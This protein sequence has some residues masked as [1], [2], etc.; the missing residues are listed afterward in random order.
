MAT[1][2]FLA[3]EAH[4]VDHIAPVWAALNNDIRGTFITTTSEAH[5]RAQSYGI[6]SIKGVAGASLTLVA[7]YGDYRKTTG[8]VVLMEHGVGHTYSNDH[9][10]YAG[11]PGKDRVVLFL[12]PNQPTAAKNRETYPDKPVEVIGV[13]KLDNT[14]V[15]PPRGRTAAISF[16]WDARIAPESRTA[17]PHY[18]RILPKLAQDKRFNLIGHA[19][20]RKNWPARLEAAYKA[21]K[22]PYVADF[23]EVL[24][25][26]D[27][28][29][30]DVSSTA[31]EFAAAGRPV[32]HLNAPWYRRRVNHGIRYWNYL[33]GPMVD[34][35]EDLADTIANVLDNPAQYEHLRQSAA[36]V[37]TPYKGEATQRA[38]NT[39]HTFLT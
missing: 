10:S 3:S 22:I 18:R 1:V 15:R 12:C 4:Y 24:K 27:V 7:S 38:A 30:V 23:Q 36:M 2:N 35:P 37:V 9:P 26:A 28:Y 13:P 5:E 29:I 19:H 39:L 6:D 33:P 32:I 20:P 21:Y 31:Y 17:L 34:R 25:E 14:P 11:S 8:P 16:H